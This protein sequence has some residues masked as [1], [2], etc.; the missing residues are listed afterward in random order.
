MFN[1]LKTAF[2]VILLAGMPA[3]ATAGISAGA[4]SDYLFRKSTSLGVLFF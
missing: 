4:D 3:M 1:S 2:A